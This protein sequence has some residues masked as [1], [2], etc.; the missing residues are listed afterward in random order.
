VDPLKGRMLLR[1]ERVRVRRAGDT[2]EWCEGIVVIASFAKG[3]VQV[4]ALELE[5]FVR[6]ASGYVAGALPLFIDRR[7]A[8]VEGLT[9]DLYDIEVLDPGAEVSPQ[10]GRPLQ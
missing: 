7:R 8:L 3:P 9:G 4:I 5:G 2:G 10:P 1:G 6:A